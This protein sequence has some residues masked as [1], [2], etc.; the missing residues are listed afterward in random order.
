[1]CGLAGIA[2]FGAAPRRDAEVPVLHAMTRSVAHRGPDEQATVREGQ[3][4]L[5][6][7]R[8]ALVAP[9]AG[10]QPIWTSD[11]RVVL[12]ANGEVYN[13]RQ[14]H[15]RLTTAAE[16][17]TGSDCEVL[18]YLYQERGRDFL[19]DVHGMFAVVLYDVPRRR[20]VLARDRFGIKPLYFHR[21]AERIV[22]ASEIKALFQDP[23]TPREI[24][25]RAAL[26]SPVLQSAPV[27]TDSTPISW[28]AGIEYVQPG[29]VM[30]IDLADGRTST[31]RYWEFPGER[32]PVAASDDEATAEYRRLLADSVADCASADAELGLLLSG[33]VDSAAVAALAVR[34]TALHTFTVLN[35]ATIEGGD[36][37]HADLVAR[38]LGLTNH[39]VHLPLDHRPTP[40]AWRRFLWLMEHPMAGA[41]AYLKHEMY[42]YARATRPDLK[43][44]LLGAASDEFN[45]GY[46]VDLAG[47]GDWATFLANLS[48]LARRGEARG[49][50]TATV[51]NETLGAPVLRTGRRAAGDDDYLRYLACEYRKIYQ[52]NVWHEDRSAAGSG[53]EA[54]VPFLDHRLVELVAGLPPDRRE[55]L[56]WNKRILRDAVRDLLPAEI[57]E[58]EKVPF[59]HGAG[60]HHTQRM[61]IRLLDQRG[62]ELVTSALSG[63]GARQYLDPGAVHRMIDGMVAGAGTEA[64]DLL[65][66][67]VNLGLLEGMLADLPPAIVD[68]PA[69]PVPRAWPDPDFRTDGGHAIARRVLG[70]RELPGHAVPAWTAGVLVLDA[71][72]GSG[73]RF[74][75]RDGTIEFAVDRDAPAWHT[76]L[77]LIDGRHDLTGLLAAVGARA[78]DVIDPLCTAIDAGLLTVDETAAAAPLPEQVRGPVA[79][80]GGH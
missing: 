56:L 24:D 75:V 35:P 3:V 19:R 44:M 67:L 13:H 74:I 34:T 27:F 53:I 51:W 60:V 54:R 49:D 28:F 65:L 20:L 18:A 30:E 11:R 55:H 43:G 36:A 16:M 14:L 33:G 10:D 2:S 48:L 46:S 7:T 31:Y 41:E 42:R 15:R 78:G 17:R 50:L 4:A 1:M 37:S 25:W 22:L 63:P 70:W 26:A 68:Q 62:R 71:T 39:Q 57:V 76:M 21:D 29:T 52:Y 59:V 79:V 45:G 6:F 23:R 40:E 8:L 61:L 73:S 72:D 64:V 9:D 66:R 47:G 38:R 80:A 32:P 5:G 69:P 58:R 12:I 77:P